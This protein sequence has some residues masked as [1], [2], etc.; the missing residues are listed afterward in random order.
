MKNLYKILI[1]IGLID[2]QRGV[3]FEVTYS[4]LI[5]DIQVRRQLICNAKVV[6]TILKFWFI[7]LS[8]YITRI[9]LLD[10]LLLN[11]ITRLFTSHNNLLL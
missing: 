4:G 2:M 1:N 8:E 11:W 10:C 5:T 6:A 7:E 3:C 9:G